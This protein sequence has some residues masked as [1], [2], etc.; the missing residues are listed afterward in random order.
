[1]DG[2]AR[3]LNATNVKASAALDAE[4]REDASARETPG[5]FSINSGMR[6]GIRDLTNSA[7]AVGCTVHT[8]ASGL[9]SASAS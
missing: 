7:V 2:M 9:A 1:M 8:I 4:A 5:G 3:R 6:S